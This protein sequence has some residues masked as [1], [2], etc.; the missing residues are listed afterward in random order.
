MVE[1]KTEI[2][3]NPIETMPKRTG[4]KC[5]VNHLNFL[6]GGAGTLS[7]KWLPANELQTWWCSRT[8]S[9][10]RFWNTLALPPLPFTSNTTL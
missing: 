8:N 10:K 7:S 6:L 3:S 1:L 5:F 9:L 2:K 4:D